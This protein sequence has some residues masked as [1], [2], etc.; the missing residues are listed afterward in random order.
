MYGGVRGEP[1]A[2]KEPCS[3]VRDWVGARTLEGLLHPRVVL[4]HGDEDGAKREPIDTLGCRCSR[5]LVTCF[6][7]HA[8]GER[9]K[10]RSRLSWKTLEGRNPREH[11]AAGGLNPCRV[12]GT[13]GR[14]ESQEPRP[15]GPAQ[16]YGGG[17]TDRL[18]G[19]RAHLSANTGGYLPRGERS[20]GWIPWALPVWNRTGTGSKGGNRHEGNQTLK[21]ERSGPASLR[22]VDLR[23]FMCCRE[24]KPKRGVGR[25]RST[26]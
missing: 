2:R 18:N 4:R 3:N 17:S 16:R 8:R 9:V 5:W 26:D 20:E 19:R 12:R 13:L 15:I 23:S 1:I 10:A 21:T 11:P 6:A 14:V 25:S 7:K 22:E 24:Q